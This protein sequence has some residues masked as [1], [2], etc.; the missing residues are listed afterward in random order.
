MGRCQFIGIIGKA[1]MAK[2]TNTKK[3]VCIMSKVEE[4]TKPKYSPEMFCDILNNLLSDVAGECGVKFKHG[5]TEEGYAV[6]FPLLQYNM[7]TNKVV[8]QKVLL[9]F[10]Q[11]E[12]SNE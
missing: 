10:P 12:A 7:E 2:I 4:V 8:P 1:D 3:V 11:V 6:I 5:N 9:T